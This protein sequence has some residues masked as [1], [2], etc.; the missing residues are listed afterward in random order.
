MSATADIS[1]STSRSRTHGR[2]PIVPL[3]MLLAGITG[4]SFAVVGAIPMV[5]AFCVPLVLAAVL[6]NR[7]GP[8][9]LL[10]AGIPAAVVVVWAVVYGVGG[11]LAADGP[12]GWAFVLGAGGVALGLLAVV[13][14]AA[15]ARL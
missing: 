3:S 12:G 9:P 13:V 15:A 6:V 1:T 10:L 4:T 7:P 5:V 8:L 14:R 2:A 11:G